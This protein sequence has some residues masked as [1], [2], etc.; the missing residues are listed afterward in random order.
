MKPHWFLIA[1]ASQARLL[2]AEPD[3]PMTVVQAYHHPQSRERSSTLGDDKS[4]REGHNF[5]GA[6]YQPHMDAQHKEHLRFAHE[7]AL[8]LEQGVRDGRCDGV[9][10]FASSPFLGELKQALGD[11][12]RRALAGTHDVDLTALGLGEAEARIR[13]AMVQ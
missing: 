4:G 12:G 6:A 11:A 1:N 7:L 10:L 9:T 5:G 2:Q 13:Q 8:A 3:A